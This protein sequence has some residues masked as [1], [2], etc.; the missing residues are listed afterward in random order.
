M[1]ENINLKRKLSR[2]EYKLALPSIQQRLYDLEKASWD[3]GMA[4]VIV[5]EGWDASGKG[6]AIAALTQRLDPRGFKLH[7]VTAPRTYEQQRPWLW[8]FWLK[9]P[10][11]GEMVIFD[12]SWYLRVLDER[13]EGAIPEKAWRDAYRDIVEFERTLADDG[14]AIV[15]FFLH[16]SRKEQ[17]ERFRAIEADP[18]EAWRVTDADWARYKKYEQYLA[19]T[20]EMLELTESEFA[21]WT[22]VEA[23]SK[24]YARKKIF[25]TIVSVMEKRLGAEAPPRVEI[26]AEVAK[27]AD[28]RA[29]MESLGGGEALMLETLDLTRKLDREA[30]VREVTAR[31]IQLRELGYQVYLQKRP[32]II[33]FEGWD[34]AGKGGAIKRVTEKLDPRGYV[35]YS[36]AAP[37]GEDK[38]RHYLYRFWRRLPERGQI[39]VF[40]RTW[41]GR[42]LVERVEGFAAEAEWKRA[43]KEI[44]S[45]ERQLK[46][47]GIILAKFWIH[48]SR[49][50]KLRRFEE[51]KAIG[52]KSWKLTD[53]DWRNRQKWGAYEEAVEEML[54]KTSTRTAPWCLVEGN[55]KY[56]AR[57]RVLSRLVEILSKELDYQPAN[58]LKR[59]AGKK[60]AKR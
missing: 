46:D 56:W 18:L 41:Y 9:V 35:V 43:Y 1:L 12:R 57:T 2:E 32:A 6:T 27:D 45:F 33:L 31:Q 19:A 29:A 58:P 44:N 42:V 28:L 59:A 39:A 14:V 23:T 22:I 26:P 3:H 54:V 8:R 30:Y 47:F 10:D 60:P 21:P 51:R 17:K 13:V 52:Y 4:T 50:E 15:K 36:I 25:E 37:Q 49:E 20:E 48:I 34:A 5:F 24:W 38:T 7:P 40:D 55:D 53:E 16:I 11:R